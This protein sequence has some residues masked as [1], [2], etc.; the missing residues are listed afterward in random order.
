MTGILLGVFDGYMSL[1]RNT[2]TSETK[3]GGSPTY[4][5]SLSNAH[6]SLIQEWTTC[7]VC[8][9]P[10][11][12]VLQA[13]SPLPRSPAS[14]H[15]M[16]YI[17]CCNSD[18]CAHQPSS[19]WCAFT[20]QVDNADEEVLSDT[21]SDIIQTEPIA[22]SALPSFT[23]PPCYVDIVTEPKK[24]VVVP[25]DLEAEMIRVAEENAKNP[26]LMEN[27]IREL[28]R[29]IDLNDKPS[30]YEF[31]KFR[32]RLS[33]EPCQVIRYYERS[34]STD[35]GTASSPV[36]S[37]PLFMRPRKV[38]NIRIPPCSNCGAALIHELQVMPTTVYYLRVKEYMP[39]GALSGDDGVDWG[40]V[41]VF[42]CS[43]DC[44]RDYQGALLRKEYVFVEKAP[45]EQDEL[46]EADGR[47]NLR[48]FIVGTK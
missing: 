10:M 24:E 13:F 23:F 32:R 6:R 7:G 44:S 17:F 42:V 26:D 31:D 46:E 41:T 14:H 21:N 38:K 43:K 35:G 30:D 34:S 16:M 12:L 19:S 18:A 29:T 39:Q 15:R 25:T 36:A 47:V 48:T 45:E 8:G 2:F 4:L 5:S 22:A 9:R 33:R 1:E 28:E 27:D 3:I 20:F 37:P 40:S 11:F